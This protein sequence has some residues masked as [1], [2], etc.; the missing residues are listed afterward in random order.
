MNSF[1]DDIIIKRLQMDKLPEE[2]QA[3]ILLQMGREI[4]E[5]VTLRVLRDMSEADQEEFGKILEAK[6]D[7]EE[8]LLNF[9]RGKIPD[10]EE[11]IKEE[12]EGFQKESSD[13]LDGL[14]A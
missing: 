5:R 4:Y 11:I 12:V 1:L 3:A 13:F 2:Q 7:D 6:P 8:A 14:S 10:L 9:M